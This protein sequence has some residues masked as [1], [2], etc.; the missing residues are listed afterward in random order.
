MNKFSPNKAEQGL[1]QKSSSCSS[2][3]Q[4]SSKSDLGA[5]LGTL[6]VGTFVVLIGMLR[7]TF[8]HTV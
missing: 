6:Q 8:C 2:L 1:L 7:T 3:T 5:I 4:V